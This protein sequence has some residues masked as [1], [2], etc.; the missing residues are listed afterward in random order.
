M[1]KAIFILPVLMFAGINDSYAFKKG[2]NEGLLIK[3]GLFGKI[4]NK[5]EINNKCY[6]IYKKDSKDKYIKQNKKIF[7]QGCVQALSDF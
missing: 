5:K 3:Q 1:K 2:F 4:L 7:M 6:N